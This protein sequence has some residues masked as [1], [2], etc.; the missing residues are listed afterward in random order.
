MILLIYRQNE[1]L[2]GHAQKK[3]PEKESRMCLVV[4]ANENFTHRREMKSQN[5]LTQG[6]ETIHFH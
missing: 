5:I 4:H 6:A 1:S 3:R 2:T